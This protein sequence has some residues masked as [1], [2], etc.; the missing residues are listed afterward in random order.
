MRVKQR[1][2]RSESEK[3]KKTEL[4]IMQGRLKQT[5][6]NLLNPFVFEADDE[7]DMCEVSIEA[8]EG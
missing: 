1:K 6:D 5:S 3:T 8:K 4:E 7:F 2:E